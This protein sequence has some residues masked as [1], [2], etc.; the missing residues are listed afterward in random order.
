MVGSGFKVQGAGFVLC[1]GFYV[2]G[3]GF[4]VLG[5]GFPVPGSA[6]PCTLNLEPRTLNPR[7]EN[8]PCTLNIGPRTRP[9]LIVGAVFD[10]R[11]P[12]ACTTSLAAGCDG[13]AHGLSPPCARPDPHL[14]S[15]RTA[16]II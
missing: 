6:E 16:E 1:A 13:S 15:T 4:Y 9:L 8:E 11:C 14:P 2:L 5:A 12:M 7:A 10:I 3:A